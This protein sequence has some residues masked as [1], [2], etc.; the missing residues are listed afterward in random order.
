[1]F[2]DLSTWWA[3]LSSLEQVYWGIAIPFSLLFIVQMLLTFFGGDADTDMDDHIDFDGDGDLDVGGFHIFTVK[4]LIG[5]FTIFAWSG[6]ASISSQFTMLI[7]IIIS[8]ASGTIM[9]LIMATLFYLMTKMTHS[10]TLDM[11]NAIGTVGDVYLTIP[12]KRQGVGKV[13][14]KV[15]GSIRTLDAMTNDSE[16]LP[17]GTVV[18]V[19]DI[20]NDI[21]IVKK[22]R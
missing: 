1:M 4:N 7:T 5:F 13:Q 2:T 14:I 8:I 11:K 22:H 16:K 3:N 10:G 6:L 17:T 19:I 12:E 21:V 18:E 9:M 15:Q 20:V